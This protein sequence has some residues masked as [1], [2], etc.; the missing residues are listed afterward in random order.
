MFVTVSIEI[1]VNVQ[2]II[3]FGTKEA[4]VQQTV[5]IAI[6]LFPGEVPQFYNNSGQVNPSIPF[7]KQGNSP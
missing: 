7:P 6:G 3:P 5:P 2:I 4:M 1:Q